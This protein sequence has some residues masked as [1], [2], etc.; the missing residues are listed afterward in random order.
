MSSNTIIDV[1]A[2]EATAVPVEGTEETKKVEALGWKA[3]M[4]NNIRRGLKMAKDGASKVLAS[5]REFA[6][7]YLLKILVVL[8]LGAVLAG[9]IW[10]LVWIGAAALA[11]S[12]W[13]LA[14][15]IFFTW[16]IDLG[17]IVGLINAIFAV[18]MAD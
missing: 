7:H 5:A 14:A 4:Q 11:V 16:A 12:G 18:I 3:S 9:F 17:V 13:L 1:E 2:V 6:R 8:L 10:L 15:F